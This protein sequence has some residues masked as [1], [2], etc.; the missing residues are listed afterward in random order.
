MKDKRKLL[1]CLS[2]QFADLGTAPF[3]PIIEIAGFQRILIENH[4][5]VGQYS[6]EKV[7]VRV[8]C[9]EI[10]VCGNNLT[11][12]HMTKAKLVIIGQ[13]DQVNLTRRGCR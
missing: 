3:L 10:S 11:L 4:H 13:V 12:C 7:T 8:N 1:E 6:T 5:G 9:G 2:L